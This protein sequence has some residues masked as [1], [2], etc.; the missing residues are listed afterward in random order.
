MAAGLLETKEREAATSSDKGSLLRDGDGEGLE[1]NTLYHL[2]LSKAP[3]VPLSASPKHAGF[4]EG[5][6]LLGSLRPAEVDLSSRAL[7]LNSRIRLLLVCV[8]R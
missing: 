7:V 8:S 6:Y 5:S 2:C 3:A 4:S 1:K